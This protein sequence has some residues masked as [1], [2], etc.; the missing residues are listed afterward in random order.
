MKNAIN[1]GLASLL[2]L[3]S[4]AAA[5]PQQ[6]E[7]L[8]EKTQYPPAYRLEVIVFRHV[9]GRSDRTRADD[10]LDFTEQLNPLLIARA[11]EV[12]GRHLNALAR[13]LPVNS[14]PGEVDDST[15]F[16]QTEDELIRPIPPIYAS[17]GDLSAPT[18][19]VMT[20]LI[21]APEYEPLVARAWIQPAGHGQY[22][23]R[24]RIHDRV[25]VSATEP[26]RP[27]N[28]ALLAEILPFPPP[29]SSPS[30]SLEIYRLDGTVR[31]RRRQ[32][33]HVDLNLVWQQQARTLAHG[34]DQRVD[35]GIDADAQ[36]WPAG[37]SQDAGAAD[38][39][40][41]ARWQLHRV[42]QSRVVQT[43]GLEYFDSSLLGVLVRIERFERV[44]PETDEEIE[45]NTQKSA[46]DGPDP[47]TGDSRPDAGNASVSG[48]PGRDRNPGGMTSPVPDSSG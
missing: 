39:D 47:P 16:L 13:F 38:A 21:A 42:Q 48:V 45:D 25:A 24:L 19:R 28:P 31:L 20:R 46:D 36:R 1:T 8:P 4:T 3:A 6:R 11:H 44:V 9:D 18:Q 37:A 5:Q 41:E 2:L 43:G 33:L 17:L 40:D 22:T 32:F 34:S 7:A 15:P 23:A 26:A 14:L 35:N 30:R 27:D 10:A 12:A 29:D